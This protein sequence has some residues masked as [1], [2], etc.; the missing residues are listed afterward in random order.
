[1]ND[2]YTVNL[3]KSSILEGLVMFRD[4]EYNIADDVLKDDASDITEPLMEDWNKCLIQAL[5][6][7]TEIVKKDN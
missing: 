4:I 3:L 2:R 1:M 6:E 7:V 5:E